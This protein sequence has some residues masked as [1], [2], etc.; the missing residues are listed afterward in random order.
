MRIGY[1]RVGDHEQTH[2]LQLE[3]LQ[4]AGCERIYRDA[5]SSK[6]PCTRRPQFQAAMA[7]LREGDTLVTWRLDRLGNRVDDLVH[8][9]VSLAQRGIGLETLKEDLAI[10]CNTATGRMQFHVFAMLAEFQNDVVSERTL[11]GLTAARARGRKGGRKAKLTGEALQKA[12]ELMREKQLSINEIARIV[13]VS[14][15]TLY[16][17]LN[18]DG[19]PRRTT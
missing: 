4:T 9:V 18:P 16:R 7:C 10:D 5:C 12:G 2:A 19:S 14:R 11:A 8:Q 15:S 1:A 3:A 6:V 13:G 17:H